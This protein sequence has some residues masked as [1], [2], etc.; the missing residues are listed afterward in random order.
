[1]VRLAM[2]GIWKTTRSPI[3]TIGDGGPEKISVAGLPENHRNLNGS[4]DRFN[5]LFQFAVL[6]HCAANWG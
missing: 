2:I 5:S 3:A 4:F 6:I 1:M